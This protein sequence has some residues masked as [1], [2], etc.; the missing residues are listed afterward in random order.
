MRIAVADLASGRRGWASS[1]WR[2]ERGQPPRSLRARRAPA[3]CP[4]RSPA[5]PAAHRTVPVSA[6]QRSR[7]CRTSLGAADGGVL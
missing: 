5:L 4:R 7:L 1:Q 6:E 2:R 3:P